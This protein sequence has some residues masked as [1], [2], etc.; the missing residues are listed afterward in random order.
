MV[1]SRRSG[2]YLCLLEQGLRSVFLLGCRLFVLSDF[3]LPSAHQF[4]E[5]EV[6][7]LFVHPWT[8]ASAV[9]RA[10]SRLGGCAGLH[11]SQRWA[12]LQRASRAPWRQR[13]TPASAG[14]IGPA[15]C[16][17]DASSGCPTLCRPHGL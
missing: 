2:L 4:L 11:L 9:H 17:P 16:V 3:S 12:S 15:V 8:W 6:V 14:A 10:P 5:I 7:L 1:A 13:H